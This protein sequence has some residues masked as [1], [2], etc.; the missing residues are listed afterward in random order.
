[1]LSTFPGLTAGA[2]MDLRWGYKAAANTV[3]H[4]A[5]SKIKIGGNIMNSKQEQAKLREEY[6]AIQAKR[7]NNDERMTNYCTNKVARFVWLKK[8][9]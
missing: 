2:K 7:W 3:Y 9:G 5:A 1:M 4:A 8:G 6:R